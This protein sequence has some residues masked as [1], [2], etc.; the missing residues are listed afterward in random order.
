MS[1]ASNAHPAA[2]ASV[3]QALAADRPTQ[4][5]PAAG[6]VPARR[7]IFPR[8]ACPVPTVTIPAVTLP[9]ERGPLAGWRDQAQTEELAAVPAP[10]RRSRPARRPARRRRS[11]ARRHLRRALTGTLLAVVAVTGLSAYAAAG[12]TGARPAAPCQAHVTCR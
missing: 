4:V 9:D 3:A 1:T 11:V 12:G 10:G 6:P 8:G 7:S 5:L 2:P